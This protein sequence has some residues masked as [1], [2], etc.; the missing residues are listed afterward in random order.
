MLEEADAGVDVFWVEAVVFKAQEKG[1]GGR[2]EG[3]V[4]WYV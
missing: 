3:I 4:G 1:A 2:P